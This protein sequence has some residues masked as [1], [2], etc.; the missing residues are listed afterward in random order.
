MKLFMTA[1]TNLAVI[2]YCCNGDEMDNG[3][4]ASITLIIKPVLRHAE[5]TLIRVSALWLQATLS[6][7]AKDGERVG[8]TAKVDEDGPDVLICSLREGASE[9]QSLDLIFDS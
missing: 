7:D 4:S 1:V 5:Y 8:V 2:S 6:L 3:E 9:S